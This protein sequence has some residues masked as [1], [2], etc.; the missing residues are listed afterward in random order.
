[1]VRPLKELT[2]V[3]GAVTKKAAVTESLAGIP[4]AIA[5]CSGW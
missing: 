2:V 4:E 3:A 5:N 1:M